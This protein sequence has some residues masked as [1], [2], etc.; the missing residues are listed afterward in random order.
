[1][2][3]DDLTLAFGGDRNGDYRGDRDDAAALAH[4]EVSG[5][6]PEVWPFADQRALEEGVHAL[7][8]VLHGFETLDFEMPLIPIA[9]TR[10]STRR[11]LTPAI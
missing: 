4:L 9:C 8:D 11:V 1:M 2:Q 6:Q 3:A 10:S 5:V 7:V